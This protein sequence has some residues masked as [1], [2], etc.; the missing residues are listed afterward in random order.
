MQNKYQIARQLVDDYNNAF[1]Q[2]DTFDHIQEWLDQRIKEEEKQA[3]I[4]FDHDG[5]VIDV[6]KKHLAICECCGSHIKYQ[7]VCFSKSF[8]PTLQ[9]IL[10]YVV[11]WQ[12]N[13]GEIKKIIEISDLKLTHTEYGNLNRLANFGLLYRQENEQ[14]NRIKDGTYWVPAKRIFQFLNGEWKVAK[15]YVVKSTTH[16]RA[17][18]TERISVDQLPQVEWWTDYKTKTMPGYVTY[19]SPDDIR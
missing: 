13:T 17:T 11:D 5:H 6:D 1:L 19:I 15:F 9:K 10:D 2:G 12:R 18:S 3:H 16:E 4:T 8:I 14:G 7:K